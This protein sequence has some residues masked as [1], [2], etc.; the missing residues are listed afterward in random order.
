[1]RR[2]VVLALG[3]AALAGCTLLDPYETI[4][5]RPPAEAHDPRPRVGICYDALANK[6]EQLLAAAQ[7]ACGKDATPVRD[8]T[9][10]GLSAMDVCPVLLPGRATFICQ[11]NK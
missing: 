3:V 7:D 9:D 5:L 4:P 2:V 11:K 6:P 10:Y 1:M 8:D